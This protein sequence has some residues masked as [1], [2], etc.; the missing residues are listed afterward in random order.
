MA[1]NF[2][3]RGARRQVV[4]RVRAIELIVVLISLRSIRSRGKKKE[5]FEKAEKGWIHS[6][7]KENSDSQACEASICAERMWK[8]ENSTEIARSASL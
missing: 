3:V 4:A 8:F 2:N 1:F 6:A 7:E 5:A